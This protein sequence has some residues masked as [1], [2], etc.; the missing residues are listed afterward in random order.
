[1]KISKAQRWKILELWGKVAKDRG[2]KVSD[3]ALRLATIGGILGRELPSLDDVERLAECTK[4]FAELEAMLGVSL[5]AGLEATQPGRNRKRNFKWLIANEALPCLAVYLPNGEVGA[6]NYLLEVM[7]GK[8]RW[9]KTDRP[10]SDPRLDDFDDRTVEQIFWTLNAR[11]NSKRKAAGDSG[12]EMCV[13]AKIPCRCAACRR[14]NSPAAAGVVLPPLPVGTDSQ[15]E[16]A[17][18]LTEEGNANPF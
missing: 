2:W 11:L 3:R 1:M 4:V 6:Y 15:V 5:R 7:A 9:R 10:E 13:K 8:S 16:T 12:H 17:E 14:S 18:I